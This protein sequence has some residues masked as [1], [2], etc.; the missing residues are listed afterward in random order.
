MLV[1]GVIGYDRRENFAT[2]ITPHGIQDTIRYPT[3][4]PY[5]TVGMGALVLQESVTGSY[6]STVAI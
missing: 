6:A 1:A 5:R 2:V 3:A 4:G